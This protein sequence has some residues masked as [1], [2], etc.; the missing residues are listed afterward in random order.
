MGAE[1]HDLLRMKLLY[2]AQHHLFNC[3]RYSFLVH[4]V[5]SNCVAPFIFPPL[6]RRSTEK[7]RLARSVVN[8]EA[9][10]HAGRAAQW[11]E[12]EATDLAG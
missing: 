1:E 11:G 8:T 9:R 2:D 5:P 4:R 10:V 7:L 6:A 3:V 12:S